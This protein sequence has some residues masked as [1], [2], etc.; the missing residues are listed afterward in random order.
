MSRKTENIEHPIIVSPR[1]LRDSCINEFAKIQIKRKIYYQFMGLFFMHCNIV[2]N[3]QQLR[4]S[5]YAIN[6]L[7]MACKSEIWATCL[8]FVHRRIDNLTINLAKAT[9]KI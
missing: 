4:G 9:R 8:R 5:P 7:K 1:S 3:V 6:E 2:T